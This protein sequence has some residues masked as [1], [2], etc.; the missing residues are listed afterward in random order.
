MKLPM[1]P[2]VEIDGRK[3]FRENALVRILL[4]EASERG[5]SLNNLAREEATTEEWEQ[6]Y[7]LIG[8]SLDGYSELRRVS[9]ESYG[10]ACVLAENPEG[11]AK[12]AR[13]EALEELL[14]E[15]RDGMRKGVA[16]LYGIHPD[17]LTNRD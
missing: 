5:Y 6:F 13:I 8:Y 1:Q 17:D 16:T 2:I 15:T 3:R 10:A 7:Q 9:D 4:D 12:D 14:K 11:D